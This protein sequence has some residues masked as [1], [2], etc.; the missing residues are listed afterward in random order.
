MSVV[1]SAGNAVSI[2]TTVNTY[3][4]SKVVSPSTGIVFNNQMDD[5]SSP[6]TVNY[7]GL[8]ASPY[9]YPQ[10]KQSL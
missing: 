4:G 5:F 8:A 3:F 10:V 2:T 1:D 6:Q 7:F 9:N